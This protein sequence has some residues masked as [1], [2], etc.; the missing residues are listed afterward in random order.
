M[1]GIP[2]LDEMICLKLKRHDKAQCAR[3]NKQWHKVISPYL[4]HD[5]LYISGV[6][7]RAA[8]RRVVLED[9]L[10]EQQQ[11]QQQQ[12]LQKQ[13]A[14]YLSPLKKYCPWIRKIP[15]PGELL[16]I[17]RPQLSHNQAQQELTNY[18]DTEP[19]AM[20]LTRHFLKHCSAVEV[21]HLCLGRSYFES[22]DLLET[23]AEF[24]L[25][26]VHYL[27]V[28]LTGPS[29]GIG[30]R[31]DP[32]KFKYL[33]G[34]CSRKLGKLSIC[35]RLQHD[36]E[37]TNCF[38]EFEEQ[39]ALPRLQLKVL[40]LQWYEYAPEFSE[41]WSWLWRQCGHLEELQL[42]LSNKVVECL[43]D[44][45]LTCM[46]NLRRIRLG[47]E[48]A[49][50]VN[51]T[52]EEIAT[53][54]SSCRIGWESVEIRHNLDF[55]RASVAALSRHYHTLEALVVGEG[56]FQSDDLLL[57][58]SSTPN[59]RTLRCIGDGV[60]QNWPEA[61][62][63][64]VA[65]IDL[66]HDTTSLKTWACEA[67]LRELAIKITNIPRPDLEGKSGVVEETCTNR[68]REIQNRVYERLAR[69][70][71]LE[72]L[73]LGHSFC[74]FDG[75]YV[76]G[77]GGFQTDCLEMSLESG[78]DKLG[79]LKELRELNLSHMNTRIQLKEIKWMVEH[80]PKLRIICGLEGEE[81]ESED[82]NDA[83][84]EYKKVIG[85]LKEFHPEIQVVDSS[86]E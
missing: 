25:P 3:V 20:D 65:F 55:H 5:M 15:L 36:E 4:W 67:S 70:T 60:Y 63:E 58:L 79:G 83:G 23:T 34:R 1:I 27:D 40:I 74:I 33:L 51:L 30:G 6:K 85:W 64:S 76:W 13:S 82:S 32:R 22:E 75:S 8:F 68:G 12:N 41:F 57:L 9:Y 72:T 45:M 35:C 56:K 73:W 47:G 11:Q 10:Q 81:E 19:T 7:Q 54:L 46:P 86:G 84:N 59:L 52:D 43:A 21:D 17:F 71:N 62:I 16:K 37:E 61:S 66:D 44:G 2:E 69:F 77:H 18:Q 38:R 28:A 80:W 50:L 29:S 26:H 39:E 31:I 42:Y 78:L 53:L 14:H 24:V 49:G 48:N